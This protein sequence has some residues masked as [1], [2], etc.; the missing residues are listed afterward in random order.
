LDAKRGR[1][2]SPLALVERRTRCA[3]DPPAQDADA[4]A[5]T[6]EADKLRGVVLD[7]RR[8]TMTVAEL[9]KS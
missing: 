3:S 7:P 4:Y 6:I 1:G 8:S 9:A 5:S 2:G